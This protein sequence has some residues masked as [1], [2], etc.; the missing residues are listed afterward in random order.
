M[1]TLSFLINATTIHIVGRRDRTG[2]LRCVSEWLQPPLYRIAAS[3]AG[4]LLIYAAVFTYPEERRGLHSK[5]EEAFALKDKLVFIDIAVDPGEHV[6]P[7][8]IKGG[9]MK[10]M[11]LS[12]T[13]RT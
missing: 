8:A 1:G 13:E 11:V 7:M 4:V 12:K 9:A 2:D 3:I 5:L 10:D 6:Y